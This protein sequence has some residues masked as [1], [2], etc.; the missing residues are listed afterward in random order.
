[1]N[2]AVK[3]LA[4]AD[5]D[6]FTRYAFI[7]D[8]LQ[9]GNAVDDSLL[10]IVREAISEG[11]LFDADDIKRLNEALLRLEKSQAS[12]VIGQ[13]PV[14]GWAPLCVSAFRTCPPCFV[15]PPYEM[16]WTYVDA[17]PAPGGQ[18]MHPLSWI[19]AQ[20]VGEALP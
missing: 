20:G 18:D 13:S 8:Y 17:C 3:N 2:G 15:M 11:A 9:N 6:S 10:E 19:D 14:L 7:R 12:Q 4:S 5:V 16:P 1:M